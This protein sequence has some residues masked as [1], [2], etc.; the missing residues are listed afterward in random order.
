MTYDQ[1]KTT[2][3]R[4]YEREEEEPT[5]LELAYEQ[6]HGARQD[7][8]Y[9]ALVAAARIKELTTALEEALEYFKARYD[10]KDGGGKQVPNDE[11]RLG[12]MIDEA[13][14]GIRF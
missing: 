8:E 1:W 3:P 7:A 14:Y 12:T 4:E 13:L 11:M 2:D 9:A 10:V 5:E 6:L